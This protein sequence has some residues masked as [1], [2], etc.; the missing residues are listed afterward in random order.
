MRRRVI[1]RKRSNR[2]RPVI[3]PKNRVGGDSIKLKRR[4]NKG[5]QS[6]N[7]V[8]ERSRHMCVSTIP[9]KFT[10]NKKLNK[11]IGPERTKKAQGKYSGN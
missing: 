8:G 3:I 10:I 11:M 1:E 4:I 9:N 7:A 2:V 5:V 6:R